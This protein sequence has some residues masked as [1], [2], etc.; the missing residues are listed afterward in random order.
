M[1][2]MYDRC[3]I[4]RGKGHTN[5]CAL[6][7]LIREDATQAALT[8]YSLSHTLSLQTLSLLQDMLLSD[9]S[10]RNPIL[11]AFLFDLVFGRSS[12]LPSH[13]GLFQTSSV[14]SWDLKT[15]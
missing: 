5:M 3:M 4:E 2:H 12:N 8:T 14:P 6:D 10:S 13:R 15:G 9:F 1:Y 7:Y 11:S